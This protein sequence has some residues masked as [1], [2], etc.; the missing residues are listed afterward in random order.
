MIWDL[1][2]EQLAPPLEGAGLLQSL[3][4]VWFPAPQVTLQVDKELQLPQF[5]SIMFFKEMNYQCFPPVFITCLLINFIHLLWKIFNLYF[6]LFFYNYSLCD[7]GIKSMCSQLQFY[8][9][10]LKSIAC[11]HLKPI[12]VQGPLI[13]NKVCTTNT[14]AV[15]RFSR[16]I[17]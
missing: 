10:N 12:I 3:V 11:M 16:L 7:M 9:H 8:C 15:I 14:S 4:W 2:P 5:P 13:K 6:H 1:D 17:G